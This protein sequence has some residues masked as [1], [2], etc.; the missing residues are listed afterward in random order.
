M[1]FDE[2][3]PKSMAH[4][5]GWLRTIVN[6]TTEQRLGFA[7][8]EIAGQLRLAQLAGPQKNSRF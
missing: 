6:P 3:W 8:W 1:S 5:G 4:G 2:A 7:A